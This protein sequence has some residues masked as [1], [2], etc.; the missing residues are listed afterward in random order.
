MLQSQISKAPT[1]FVFYIRVTENEYNRVLSMCEA[2]RCTAQELF[3]KG[4]LGR[5]NLEK[6]VYLLNPDEVQEFRTALSRIGNNVN[7]I[8]RKVNTGLTEGWYQVLN[9]INR[10]L[11]D[12]NHK[13]GAKYADR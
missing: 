2:T 5:V 11:L 6:P 13:L 7:Q 3:K 12:L 10:G 4:L 8:A 1:R 9:G